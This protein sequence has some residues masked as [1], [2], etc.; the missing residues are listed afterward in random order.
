MEPYFVKK[1]RTLDELKPGQ[2]KIEFETSESLNKTVADYVKVKIPIGD[3][4]FMEQRFPKAKNSQAVIS[5]EDKD[6]KLIDKKEIIVSIKEKKWFLANKVLDSKKFRL[7]ELGTKCDFLKEIKTSVGGNSTFSLKFS[8]HTPIRGKDYEEVK[9][10]RLVV[11]GYTV[12]FRDP[13]SAPV[14]SS[15]PIPEPQPPKAPVPQSS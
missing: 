11:D 15:P 1:E 5:L 13:S 10:E 14:K 8:I 2:V 4:K 12:P 7:A 6:F 9:Q 3:E